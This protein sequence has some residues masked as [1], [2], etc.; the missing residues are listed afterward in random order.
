MSSLD[1]K[2]I[3]IGSIVEAKDF[4]KQ[5]LNA[6]VIQLDTLNNRAKLHFIDYPDSRLDEWIAISDDNIRSVQNSK[7][8]N[9][10]NENEN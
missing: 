8:E 10:V 5:W 4:D 2:H 7:L 6:R 9:H 1:I 3:E